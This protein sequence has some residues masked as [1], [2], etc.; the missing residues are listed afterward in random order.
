MPRLTNIQELSHL[1]QQMK[2]D[3]E[4]SMA[5]EILITIGMGTCGQAAGAGETWQ[6]FQK[7]LALRN[8][9]A[10]LRAVGCIGMCVKEPLVDIQINGQ[11]RISY[12][13]VTPSKVSRIIEE[14]LVNAQVV[15]EWVLGYVPTDW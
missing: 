12:N 3:L 11:Q 7:E 15:Q 2:R 9:Q 14:H 13:N 4:D 8:I 1:S 5:H 6:T 10:T